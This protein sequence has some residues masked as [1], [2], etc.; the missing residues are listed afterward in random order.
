MNLSEILMTNFKNEF[1]KNLKVAK[2]S[3]ALSGDETEIILLQVVLFLTA[4]RIR[5]ISKEGRELLS[6]LQ[7]FI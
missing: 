5:P 1:D 3:G 6:N 4:Q 2:S 7:H